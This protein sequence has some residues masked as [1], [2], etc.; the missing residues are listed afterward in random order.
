MKVVSG[1]WSAVSGLRKMLC[2]SLI[3]TFHLSPFTSLRAQNDD[4]ARLPARANVVPYEDEDDI[5][6]G[7]YRESPYYMTLSYPWNH[8]NNDS[9]VVSIREIE[10]EKYW[11]DYCVTLNVR[12]RYAC[13]VFLNGKFVGYG[14]DSRHWNEFDLND[15]LKY[16][17]KNVLKV[18]S[19]KRPE[20]AL[21]ERESGE[22]CGLVGEPF[23]VFKND[24]GVADMM[25]VADYDVATA[26]GSLS[27]DATVFNSK[28]KG[29]YYLE[30][31]IWDPQNH[32]FDRMGRWVVFDKR[33]EATVDLSRSWTNVVPWSAENPSLYTAV[34]RLRDEN[35]EEEEVVGIRFGF[36]RVEV[37]DGLLQINGR[38][39]TFKGIVWQDE[40]NQPTREGMRRQLQTLKQKNVNAVRCAFSPQLPD[41]YELCDELGFYVICDANLLPA[42]SQQRVVATDKDFIPLFQRRVENLYGKYK[43]YTSIVAWSL[44]DTRDNGICM[45]AAYKRLKDLEKNRPVIFSGAD[46]SANTDV[47]AFINPDQ[48]LL[49]QATSKTGDRPFLVLAAPMEKYDL[50]WKRVENTRALQ[51]A[52]VVEESRGDELKSL[53]SPFDVHLMKRTV[54]DAEFTVYNRNDFADF[55]NYILEYT[56][57]TNLRASITGGDLPVAIDGGGVEAV[58]LRVPPVKL[59]PGEE[60]FIRFDL[61]RR[62]KAGVRQSSGNNNLGTIVFPLSDNAGKKK[63]LDVSKKTLLATFET[64]DGRERCR[65]H[66]MTNEVAFNLADGTL[67]WF[68]S[69]M[70]QMPFDSMA[71][72]FENHRD[73]RRSLVALSHN[74]PASGI[75]VVDAMLRYHSLEGTLM[76]D[77]RQTYTVFATGDM[78]VD[79][80]IA[81]SDQLR[82]TLVPRVEMVH[83]FGENDTL[84]WFGLDRETPYG[85][86]Q[87]AI[88]GT[89]YETLPHGMIRDD[90]RWCAISDSEYKG[91]FVDVPDTHFSFMA[92]TKELWITPS[93]ATHS[94]PSF[95]LHLR[96][97]SP[98]VFNISSTFINEEQYLKQNQGG[99]RQEDF[100]GTTYPQVSTGMLEPPVITATEVRFSAPLTVTITSPQASNQTIIR[101]TLDGSDPTENSPIYKTPITLTTTTVVK[102]RAFGKDVPPS[103]TATRKF[104]YDYIVSTTFSRKPNTPFNVGTDTILFDGDKGSV[105]DLQRGWL[106]FSGSGVTATVMLAKQID[107]EQLTLRFA[108][109]PDNW[110]FAPQQVNVLLSSDGEHYTDTLNVAIPF[111][112]ASSEENHPREVELKVPVD[113]EGIASFKVEVNA[114]SAVPDWHRAKGLKPWVLMDEIEVSERVTGVKGSEKE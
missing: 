102:A 8:E 2:V 106:G 15:F 108:H 79:Y 60:L 4:G 20:G 5:V 64:L 35:M 26:T 72:I 44:G 77:V 30:V 9:A 19:L 78:V 81:P 92:N 84:S 50:L 36:R 55:S 52:F 43:N 74:Q 17:K 62:Q 107:I 10:V 41:F 39:V 29:R 49:R 13:R 31:E 100:I 21:L 3:L 89:Y 23:L 28:K 42:S 22:E 6:K 98:K 14:D 24:P 7:G 86:R 37:R 112:P 33:S 110:A 18:E 1:Q 91:L 104:N 54:D 75:Y 48:Q 66:T 80:T 34:L 67:E 56:I 99:E 109:V 69:G 113:K 58:K 61:T 94:K 88:P 71:L 87:S 70:G 93:I 76:C 47:V 114:L 12:S 83:S 57:Y 97:F 46:F 45:A 38:P 101:Y 59:E 40:S 73:W 111:D 53:Y 90:N 96:A 27:V 51:G 65:V 103:F 82:E 68:T 105:S 25:L 16:G 63:M 11:K 95:R 32:N 85:Q